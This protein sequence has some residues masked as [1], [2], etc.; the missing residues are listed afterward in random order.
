MSFAGLLSTGIFLTHLLTTLAVTGMMWFIQIVHY[1][2]QR[3]VGR[4]QAV[5]YERAHTGRTV[6]V[7]V[8]LMM[9]ECATGMLLLWLRPARVGIRQVWIGLVLLGIIWL[10][11]M[12]LQ[13]PQH[14]ILAKAYRPEALEALI[15]TNW[16]RTVCYSA[17]AW[18]MLAM[19]MSVMQ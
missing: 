13:V 15:S 17:R 7:V 2:L 1:P 18:L 10:S 4:E 11:T 12:L 6:A 19:V 5:A 3:M 14:K 16:I 8:S 9:I